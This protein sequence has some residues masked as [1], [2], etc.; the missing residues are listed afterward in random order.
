VVGPFNGN[1][2]GLRWPRVAASAVVP[3]RGGEGSGPALTG[4]EGSGLRDGARWG[5]NLHHAL[6]LTDFQLW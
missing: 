1:D 3:R 2:S 6:G 4:R 5:V